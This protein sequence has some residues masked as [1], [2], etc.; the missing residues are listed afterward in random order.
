MTKT[1]TE[2]ETETIDIEYQ[3]W[4]FSYDQT[5]DVLSATLDGVTRQVGRGM[6]KALQ[7]KAHVGGALEDVLEG[8]LR[9]PIWGETH[10]QHL[11][12]LCGCIFNDVLKAAKTKATAAEDAALE[13]E[14]YGVR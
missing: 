3:G 9:R 8:L 7:N 13:L 5:A 2:T 14:L 1:E 6:R 10:S 12:Q 11:P 4:A